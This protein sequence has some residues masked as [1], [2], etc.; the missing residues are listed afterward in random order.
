MGRGEKRHPE[1]PGAEGG[2]LWGGFTDAED[3]GI[4]RK[5]ALSARELLQKGLEADETWKL[6]DVARP[7]G[8]GGKMV[9][10]FLCLEQLAQG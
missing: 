5:R 8:V 10:K 6:G 1:Q 3:K 4:S 7:G 9:V 2:S